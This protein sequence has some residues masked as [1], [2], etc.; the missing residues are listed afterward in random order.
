[1]YGDDKP[2]KAYQVG[3]VLKDGKTPSKRERDALDDIQ[4]QGVETE[5]IPKKK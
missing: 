2:I 5:Y 1:M 4:R 3:D